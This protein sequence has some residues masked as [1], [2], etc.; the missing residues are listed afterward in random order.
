MV[1]AQTWR[2]NRLG[3]QV[4][5]A[6]H[7]LL[8]ICCHFGDPRMRADRQFSDQ[9]LFCWE[10][11]I[12]LQLKCFAEMAR[13]PGTVIKMQDATGLPGRAFSGCGEQ[14]FQGLWRGCKLTAL[15]GGPRG[16]Q[17]F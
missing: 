17:D 4:T 10:N 6:Q 1:F 3:K 14:G 7:N 11:T 15:Q 8:G 16:F 12:S 13:S 9:G 5:P 2:I